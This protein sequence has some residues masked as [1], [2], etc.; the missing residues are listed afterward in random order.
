M[1]RSNA[2]TKEKSLDGL[3]Y[4]IIKI[5]NNYKYNLLIFYKIWKKYNEFQLTKNKID[6]N[7]RKIKNHPP[8]PVMA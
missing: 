8:S 3:N 7:N 1:E 5:P 2:D 6:L 4:P